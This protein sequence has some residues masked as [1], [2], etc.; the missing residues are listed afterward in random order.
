MNMKYEFNTVLGE[1]D[2]YLEII[3]PI[4]NTMTGNCFNLDKILEL[5]FFYNFC[6]RDNILASL[7]ILVSYKYV[8]GS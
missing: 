6:K 4:R 3:T 7:L 8:R 2:P 1:A 5:D